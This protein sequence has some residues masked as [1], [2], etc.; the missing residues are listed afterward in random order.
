LAKWKLGILAGRGELGTQARR[1]KRGL[2]PPD[3]V[4]GFPGLLTQW[5]EMYLFLPTA[6]LIKTCRLGRRDYYL[7]SQ[8]SPC[9]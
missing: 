6:S 1:A 4:L 3:K 2:P 9:T 5:E 7:P 8:Q